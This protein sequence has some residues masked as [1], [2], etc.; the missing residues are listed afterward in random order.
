MEEKL[1]DVQKKIVDFWNKYNRKQ[2]TLIISI[3]LALVVFCTVMVLLL[4]KTDYVVLVECESASQASEVKEE[5]TDA[6][7]LYTIDNNWVVRVPEEHRVDAEMAIATSGIIAKE[8]TLEE[9]LDGNISVTEADKAR[10]YKAYLEDRL[11]VSL[12][13]LEYVRSAKVTI[14]IPENKWSVLDTDE[15]ASAA[16]VLNLKHEISSDTAANLAQWVATSLDN[17][18]T[19]SITIIDSA[20]NMLFRGTD[21]M[22]PNG[23]PGGGSQNDMRQAAM[24]IVITNVKKLFDNAKLYQSVEVSPFLD[25]SFDTAEKTEITYDTGDREQGPYK[26]SYEVEQE[27]SSGKG[28]VPGTASNDEDITY[29]IQTDEDSSSTYE[30]KKYEYAVNEIIEKTTLAKG[31]IDYEKSS[32][33]IMAS[34]YNIFEEDKVRAAGLLEE[35]TWDEFKVANAANVVMEVPEDLYELVSNATGFEVDNITIMAYRVPQFID[36][37]DEGTERTL[38]DYIPIILALVIFGLLLFVVYK[39]T[40][41]VKVF[42]TEPELSVEALLATTKENTRKPVDDI[43]LNEKSDARRAIDKFVSENPEAVASLLRNWLN[44]DWG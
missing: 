13:S 40:R 34:T 41:P 3:V 36:H 44:E 33:S 19:S 24:D 35:T 5:L 23:Y 11:R 22:D 2:R 39:S 31:T 30:L 20:A 27:N 37:V 8:Y 1:K 42:E 9:A 21:S 25:M 15:E 43:D 4:N 6:G 28:G 18:T 16:V 29:D 38:T 32:L 17:D 14:N 7:I 26:T 12:E 10:K